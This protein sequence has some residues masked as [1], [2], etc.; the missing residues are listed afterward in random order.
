MAHRV[1]RPPIS[2]F[3]HDDAK[4]PEDSSLAL[5]DWFPMQPFQ[6]SV[7]LFMP[8]ASDPPSPPGAA[9]V[10]RARHTAVGGVWRRAG[11]AISARLY[12]WTR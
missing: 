5:L 10:L 12:V 2:I 6:T 1:A 9:R 7:D 3:L 8:A 11:V 4:T